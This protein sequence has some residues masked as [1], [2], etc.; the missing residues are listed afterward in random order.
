MTVNGIH[1]YLSGKVLTYKQFKRIQKACYATGC[2]QDTSNIWKAKEKL[3]CYAY[4]EQGI[5]VFLH[6]K[7]G[8]WY[9]LRV[10]IEPCRVLGEK[11]PTA[12]AKLDRKTYKELVKHVD[13]MLKELKVPCSIDEMKLSRCD[14]TINI[15]FSCQ[16]ELMQYLRILKKSILLHDYSHVFFRKDD[17][18]AE[19]WKTANTHS[20]CIS[21]ESAS[22]LVYD[23][24]AQLQMIDR[25]DETLMDKHIL[26]LE[27]ELKRTALKRHL[28]KSSMETNYKLLS[29]ASTQSAKVVRWYL[30]RMQPQ[31][32]EYLRY[33]DAVRTIEE[34]DFG[35]KIK[36]RMLHLLRKTSDK[37]SLSA[38]LES[39][40]E[41]FHLKKNQCR[42]VLKK[43]QKL[44]ISPITLANNSPFEELPFLS[45]L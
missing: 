7:P 44:G 17:Q 16:E 27:A 41:K 10:Q 1:T 35:K 39:M 28:G 11:A 43:F 12:L 42:T 40:R 29:A 36:E 4:Q 26:R 38:A 18:K 13:R 33:E 14:L 37:G 25:C 6:S 2:V 30:K 3:F 22:F 34:A 31:C 45:V 5:K 15:E 20:Y 8:K 19:D 21:C 9:R 23:K 24:I 32:E